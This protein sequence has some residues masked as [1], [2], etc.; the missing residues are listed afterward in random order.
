MLKIKFTGLLSGI[1]I[2]LFL[3]I[4]MSGSGV[5]VSV[6]VM[7]GIAILMAVWW[8]TEAI[9][10]AATSLLPLVLFPFTGILSGDEIASSYINPIIFLFLGGFI[11]AL[12]MERWELH[13]R[14]AL[15]ITLFFGGTPVS[16][17]LG[18]MIASSFLSMWIS[19]TATCIMMLPIAL[20][21]INK[22]EQNFD[23]R[24]VSAFS[25][26]LLLSV[27][28]SCTLG[29]LA[30]L[31]GT[32]PNLV[33]VQ[34]FKILFPEAPPIS[35]GNWMILGLPVSA[36]MLITT[37]L[38]LTKIYFKVDTNIKFS[39]EILL[40][41]Y[42]KL[43]N[44]STA[45]KSVG[46]IF[47]ITVLLWIFRADL[48]FGLFV[49]PGWQNLLSVPGFIN[50]GTV[51][52]TMALILFTIPV[53]EKGKMILDQSV[54]T[55]IPWDIILL[56]GGGFALAKGFTSTGLSEFIGSQLKNFGNID[57]FFIIIITAASISFLTELTSNTATTQMI[58]PILAPVAVALGL[59]P[60]L[61]MVTATLSA[62][63][64][65]MLP[66]ATPPNTIIFAS[67]RIRVKDMVKTGFGLN[68]AGI[69][70]VSL[71]VYFF[72]NVIFNLSGIQSL[73]K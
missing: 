21:V 46:I 6:S 42:A 38:L 2:A 22:M 49:I 50:D 58:L 30:T 18:F 72:G 65:F 29:G 9:P 61:L 51:A 7:A 35:F 15:R 26:I 73:I 1:F 67:S 48:N 47:I 12:A 69:I 59:N 16:I 55:K 8:I 13:K 37:W 10:L 33:L 19:N 45:E 68:I 24:S 23:E 34:T 20:A 44:I 36:I 54:F 63:M 66:V 27:A 52:V 31:V 17:I 62:S 39:K 14:I 60:L 5:Q 43:G 64:A 11:I 41:E 3:Y 56:F 32:P 25:K 57:P 28:Y 71:L 70:I 53:K 40:E 4:L